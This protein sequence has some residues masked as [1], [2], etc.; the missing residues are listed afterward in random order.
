MLPGFIL[1]ARSDVVSERGGGLGVA[2]RG[3]QRTGLLSLQVTGRH[4]VLRP[5]ILAE[6]AALEIGITISG[7]IC[8]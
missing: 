4:G 7:K 6:K 1:R 8:R 2:G 3:S 5:A